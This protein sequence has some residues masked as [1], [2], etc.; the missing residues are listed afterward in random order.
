V[1]SD[2][3]RADRRGRFAAQ[4]LKRP[5]DRVWEGSF[6]STGARMHLQ[7]YQSATYIGCASCS[8]SS[9]CPLVR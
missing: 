6:R 4:A 3:R 9:Y 1:L 7:G 2:S 5:E 8:K